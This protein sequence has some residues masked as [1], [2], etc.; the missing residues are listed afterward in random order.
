MTK[1]SNFPKNVIPF[2]IV[3]EDERKVSPQVKLPHVRRTTF[4]SAVGPRLRNY[5]EFMLKNAFILYNKCKSVLDYH[6]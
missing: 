5:V 3:T 1:E 2:G 6:H 4:S